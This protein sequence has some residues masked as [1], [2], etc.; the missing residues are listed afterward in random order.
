MTALA[1]YWECFEGER[2][3]FIIG[4]STEK[5]TKSFSQT[6]V[7]PVC[8]KYGGY[9]IFVTYTALTIF[10]IPVLKW[11]RRY[12]AESTCCGTVYELSSESGK[13]IFRGEQTS[14]RDEDIISRADMGTCSCDWNRNHKKCG[15]CGYETD[16]DF[17]YC[18]KC[19]REF[20]DR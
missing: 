3:F 2:M 1:R 14:I 11:G 12:F 17:Q 5:D 13:R 4:I 9:R 20:A 7:C 10:F 18:P 8:G 19:G 16:E 6:F 15:Y